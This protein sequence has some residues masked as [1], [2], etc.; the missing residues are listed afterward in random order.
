[1]FA[2]LKKVKCTITS[3][4][5]EIYLFNDKKISI[6]IFIFAKDVMLCDLF[7]LKKNFLEK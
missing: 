7:D 4:L 3:L 5:H 2:F 1:M 6:F